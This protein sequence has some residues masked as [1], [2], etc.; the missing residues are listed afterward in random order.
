MHSEV[1]LY[2]ES[3]ETTLT[4]AVTD[5]SG[6]SINGQRWPELFS[7]RDSGASGTVL[8]CYCLLHDYERDTT[9]FSNTSNIPALQDRTGA[10]PPGPSPEF[11]LA[12]SARQG[13]QTDG[14]PL[15]PSPPQEPLETSA[16]QA[17]PPNKSPLPPRIA[18]A[19]ASSSIATSS[20]ALAKAMA[21]GKRLVRSDSDVDGS[22]ES[23]DSDDESDE[24]IPL[25]APSY[26]E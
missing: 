17:I 8:I 21:S 12:N 5:T 1:R 16:R 24:D 2:L 10:P 18:R 3:A 14:R 7:G 15:P 4:L 9:V 26:P 20:A 19:S 22:E 13:I 25:S 23:E 6:I 11:A